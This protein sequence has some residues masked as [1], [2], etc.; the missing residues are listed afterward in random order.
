MD[1]L[2]LGQL[3]QLVEQLH[4]GGLRLGQ[5]HVPVRAPQRT[6]AREVEGQRLHLRVVAVVSAGAHETAEARWRHVNGG[7]SEARVVHEVVGVILHNKGLLFVAALL[8]V[9]AMGTAQGHTGAQ[10]ERRLLARLMVLD[11]QRARQRQGVGSE[12]GEHR[13]AMLA[14]I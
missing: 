6:M 13:K 1:C 10:H 3:R 12:V 2:R 9:T 14:R 8:I 5:Q 11:A 7:G 4:V